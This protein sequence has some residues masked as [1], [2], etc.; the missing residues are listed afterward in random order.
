MILELGVIEP[1]E[2]EYSGRYTCL[3]ALWLLCEEVPTP[4]KQNFV[5]TL[6]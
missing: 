4:G 2:S 5:G 3:V 6:A 1:C